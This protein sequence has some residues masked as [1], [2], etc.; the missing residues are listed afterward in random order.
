M[1]EI[2]NNTRLNPSLQTN[3][4]TPN[5]AIHEKS[6]ETNSIYINDN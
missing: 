4:E 5:I 2:Y 6:K 1:F 3:P